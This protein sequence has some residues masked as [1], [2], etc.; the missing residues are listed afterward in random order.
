MLNPRSLCYD[1]VKIN[2]KS[3]EV[4]MTA[5]CLKKRKKEKKKGKEVFQTLLER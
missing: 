4:T 2:R 3:D 1:N 5:F